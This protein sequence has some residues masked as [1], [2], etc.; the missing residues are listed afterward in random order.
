M[1]I[2]SLLT[3]AT[4]AYPDNT[5]IVQGGYRLSYLKFEAR[6]NRLANALQKR[7]VRAHDHIAL[8]M[9]NGPQMLEAMFAA[10]KLGAGLVPINFRLHPHEIAYNIDNSQAST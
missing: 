1:N 7:G 10:F 9:T 6:V 5:A 8:W 2:A 3:Q 4:A